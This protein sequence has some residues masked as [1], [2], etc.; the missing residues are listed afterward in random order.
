MDF[1]WYGDE[2]VSA[3]VSFLS[4][5]QDVDPT[6]IAAVGLS[7]GG[8]E[9][10]GAAA[11]DPRIAAVVAEGATNRVAADKAWLVDEHGW[12]GT[13][14]QGIDRLTFGLTDLLTDADPP[15]A[16]RDAVRA[17]AP[18]PVLLIAAGTVSDEAPAGRFIQAGSPATV[19]L[20][21]VDGAGHT[22][23]LALDRDAWVA[24]VDA[25]LTGALHPDGPEPAPPPR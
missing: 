6:R 21:V 4:A 25:F 13:V 8:E 12:R 23:A 14:Q 10:I 3:A 22:G 11:T 24:R 2:D 15:I 16:L 19:E 18:R 7:M 5:Q 20:W 1:G 17:A 9:A